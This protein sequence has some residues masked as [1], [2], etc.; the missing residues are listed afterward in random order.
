MTILQH[1][2]FVTVSSDIDSS[3][4]Q[5]GA[6]VDEVVAA[7][8]A[9]SH[10]DEAE[11]AERAASGKLREMLPFRIRDGETLRLRPFSEVE[12]APTRALTDDEYLRFLRG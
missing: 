7:I 9:L 5:R 10:L 6:S 12:E 1:G 11:L 8:E 2:E 4:E 3:D